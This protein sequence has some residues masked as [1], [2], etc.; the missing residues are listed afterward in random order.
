MK[1]A[2]YIRV[3][4]A[5]QAEEGE[6]LK[7]QRTAIT[8]HIKS[9]EW[10]VV[11][12][13]E[14]AGI[15]GKAMKKREGLNRLLK[16]AQDKRFDAV[17]ITRVTR[18]GRSTIDTLNNMELLKESGIKLISLAEMIDFDTPMGEMVFTMLAG[19][20]KLENEMRT[21]QVMA[22][23]I[24]SATKGKPIGRRPFGRVYNKKTGQWI[25][26]ENKAEIIR[27][28][29]SE[30]LNGKSLTSLAKKFNIRY[31]TL[32]TT[33]KDRCGTSW[34]IRFD[35]G[36]VVKYDIPPILDEETIKEVKAKLDMQKLNRRVDVK[37]YV[38]S[39][40]LHCA[41]CGSA[42]YGQTQYSDKQEYT[43]Y[44]HRQQSCDGISVISAPMIEN[45]VFKTIFEDTFDE[46]GFNEAIKETFPSKQET[47]KIKNKINRDEKELKRINK[48]LEKLIDLALSKI[49]NVETIKQ[50]ETELQER[51]DT[52][53]EAIEINKRKLEKQPTDE[54]IEKQA[55]IVRLRMLDYFK[56]EERY[57]SMTYDEKKRLL[58]WLFDG[59]DETGEKHGIYVKKV[60]NKV[61]DY[62]INAKLF[63]GAAFLKGD[64]IDYNYEE[65]YKDLEKQ[66]RHDLNNYKSNVV[67]LGKKY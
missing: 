26:D 29:A 16:D 45:A 41:K 15:S 53:I 43:Y 32:I 57:K 21:Q 42:L 23:R 61:F 27:T 36:E 35:T 14:D 22:G 52:L 4:T 44:R 25:L 47:Q 67:S 13:Y 10:K 17:I 31:F 51:K 11:E 12:I 46:V 50:R 54:Q 7:A 62:R 8:S 38:L 28:I 65:G 30:Y 40:F 2:G 33:L 49:L 5:R 59:K 64:D 3:S 60:G 19:F 39:G 37:K 56:S 18:F 48:D 34:E 58:H 55:E 20:A 24:N 6:S 66:S 9:K 63:E 1:A